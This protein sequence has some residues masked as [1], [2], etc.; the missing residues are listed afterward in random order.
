MYACMMFTLPFFFMLH[1]LPVFFGNSH[2]AKKIKIHLFCLGRSDTHTHT[3]HR[4]DVIQIEAQLTLHTLLMHK[5]YIC[6]HF[7]WIVSE[8][9]KWHSKENSANSWRVFCSWVFLMGGAMW[10]CN[11][12]FASTDFSVLF[13]IYGMGCRN[14]F[15]NRI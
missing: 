8:R 7:I 5:Y 10:K 2:S 13:V 14:N 4:D 1:C 9:S 15:S 11:F 12:I 6:T 3:L